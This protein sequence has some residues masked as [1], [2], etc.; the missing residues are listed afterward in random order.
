M[1]RVEVYA[2]LMES[3]TVEFSGR[4]EAIRRYKVWS[5]A[6]ETKGPEFM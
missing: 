2:T 3:D 6:Q 4:S 5:D 1:G